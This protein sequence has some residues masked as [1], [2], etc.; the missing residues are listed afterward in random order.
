MEKYNN[1]LLVIE[2]VVNNCLGYNDTILVLDM[3]LSGD[4]D[5]DYIAWVD[6]QLTE[7]E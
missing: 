3:F 1:P 4:Y 6:K 7:Q 5:K 2:Y